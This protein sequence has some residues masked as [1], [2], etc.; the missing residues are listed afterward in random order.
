MY[1]ETTKINRIW[2]KS[3]LKIFDNQAMQPTIE[4][5][6]VPQ[7]LPEYEW[8]NRNNGIKPHS[9]MSINMFDKITRK[10]VEEN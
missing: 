3:N 2:L 10:K 8:K 4:E 7:V 5:I 6:T 9:S 1:V